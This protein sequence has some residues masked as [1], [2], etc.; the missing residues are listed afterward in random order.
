MLS[1]RLSGSVVVLGLGLAA[2]AYAVAQAGSADANCDGCVDLQDYAQLQGELTGPGCVP[3]GTGSAA[4]EVKSYVAEA[5]DG[6]LLLVPFAPGETGFV[7][8]DLT[9]EGSLCRRL[10]VNERNPING[11]VEL[12]AMLT[13]TDGF[14][15]QWN[16]GIAF[17]AGMEVWIEPAPDQSC[18]FVMMSGHTQ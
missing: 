1:N 9:L 2:L 13:T 17:A 4:H 3:L 18:D 14:T 16:S 8:T 6:S 11:T 12:K 10:M 7:M 5:V 15:F